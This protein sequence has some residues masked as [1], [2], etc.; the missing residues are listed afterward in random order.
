MLGE[1]TPV[2][3]GVSLGSEYNFKVVVALKV[4]R[5]GCKTPWYL[6]DA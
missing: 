5:A 2:A 1:K 3:Q 6:G 4:L